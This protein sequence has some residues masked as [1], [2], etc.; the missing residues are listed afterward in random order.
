MSD[1]N[2]KGRG[3]LSSPLALI[4]AVILLLFGYVAL[5]HPRRGDWIFALIFGWT[6]LVSIAL[7]VWAVK[8]GKQG[9]PPLIGNPTL[10]MVAGVSSGIIAAIAL[11]AQL[12]DRP[13]ATPDP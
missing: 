11:V 4:I 10:S 9:K 3:K 1:D 12:R 8:P 6:F 13:S 2:D 5:L 7:I